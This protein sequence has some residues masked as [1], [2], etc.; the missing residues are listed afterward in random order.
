MERKKTRKGRWEKKGIFD[1]PRV[2]ELSKMYEDMGFSVKLI[3][4]DPTLESACTQCMK[5]HPDRF[6]V[7]YTKRN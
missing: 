2:S 5:E 1:D 7:L 6:R 3:R 4:L